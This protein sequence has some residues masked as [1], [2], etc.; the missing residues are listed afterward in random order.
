MKQKP[1]PK[2]NNI[3]ILGTGRTGST[4]LSFILNNFA[5]FASFGE[6]F[7]RRGS[8][9]LVRHVPATLVTLSAKNRNTDP[10]ITAF[11]QARPRLF[12]DRVAR[13]CRWT[14]KPAMAFQVFNTQLPLATI[15]TEVLGRPGTRAMLI[16]RRAIDSYVSM[17][18]ARTVSRWVHTDTTDVK[19]AIDAGAFA[20]WYG[21]QTERYEH[22]RTY[23][24]T[25]GMALPVIRYEDDIA[26]SVPHALS[27]FSALASQVGLDLK[28]SAEMKQTGLK[29]QDRNQNVRDKVSNWAETEKSLSRRGLDEAAFSHFA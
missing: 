27:R 4:H 14:G 23:H 19:V 28:L 15:D 12:L 24:Q 2:T 17:L 26:A 1:E 25:R 29:R 13:I 11:A 5:R 3:C 6:L 16:S 10:A 8:W 22:W 9:G 21:K 18:K 7:E 20:E